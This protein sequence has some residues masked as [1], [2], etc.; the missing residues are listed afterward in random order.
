[1][2]GTG[3]FFFWRILLMNRLNRIFRI[4]IFA[5]AIILFISV[6]ISAKTVF[7]FEE[8]K[9]KMGNG[10]V[11]HIWLADGGIGGIEFDKKYG[12][13]TGEFIVIGEYDTLP[14]DLKELAIQNNV[15]VEPSQRYNDLNPAPP[16]YMQLFGLIIPYFSIIVILVML[17][18]IYRKLSKVLKILEN[19]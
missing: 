9:E 6:N 4:F 19:K 14:D 11:S 18:L 17:I 2:V 13:N 16:I 15:T 8:I 12:V 5:I 1:M 3:D 7:S 10:E